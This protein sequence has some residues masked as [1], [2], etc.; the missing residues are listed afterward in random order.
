M[1]KTK[2]NIVYANMHGS[3]E[4]ASIHGKVLFEQLKKGVL[5]T[6]E[7]H[8][9]PAENNKCSDRIFGFH[10]HEGGRCGDD[11]ENPFADAKGHYNPRGCNHPFHAGDLPPLFGNDGYA[12][13]SVFTNRFNVDEI[14]G[15]TVIIHE[16]PD[17][18]KTQPGG[19][20]GARIACGVIVH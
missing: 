14:V 17:D 5:V 9:L 20:S 15:R 2:N 18:F 10:V 19:D 6:A 11:K 3:A 13:L 7:I 12:Y 1:R 8:G 4:Y 16:M